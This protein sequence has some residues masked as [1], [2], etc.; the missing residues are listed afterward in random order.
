MAVGKE[1]NET[2]LQCPTARWLVET[3]ESL[4]TAGHLVDTVAKQETLSQTR[5]TFDLQRCLCKC[6]THMYSH[7]YADIHL[8]HPSCTSL[9]MLI[10]HTSHTHALHTYIIYTPIIYT[11]FMHTSY[12][13]AS[14]RRHIHTHHIHI[15]HTKRQIIKESFESSLSGLLR[16][17][18]FFWAELGPHNLMWGR[19]SPSL[20]CGCSSQMGCLDLWKPQPQLA[21]QKPCCLVLARHTGFVCLSWQV[22]AVRGHVGA[23]TVPWIH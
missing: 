1:S 20:G 14:W 22:V 8:T 2:R 19:G 23:G 10:M 7:W 18:I 16:I 6:S 21:A 15:T 17:R 5:S 12:T 13:H 11:C 9:Y 3:V 4:E